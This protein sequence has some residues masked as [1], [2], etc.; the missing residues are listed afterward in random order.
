MRNVWK[1]QNR[2]EATTA[3]L[4]SRLFRKLD[5]LLKG[6]LVNIQLLEKSSKVKRADPIKSEPLYLKRGTRTPSQEA[7][8]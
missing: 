8:V 6:S 2:D 1:S 5:I 4:L 7:I 3:E